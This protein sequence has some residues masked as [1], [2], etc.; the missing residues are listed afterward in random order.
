[1]KGLRILLV[2]ALFSIFL[3]SCNLNRYQGLIITVTEHGAVV[4]IET[5]YDEMPDSNYVKFLR[6]GYLSAVQEEEKVLGYRVEKEV[7]LIVGTKKVM[8]KAKENPCSAISYA[9]DHPDE[10]KFYKII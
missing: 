3:F 9:K 1:M 8:K 7:Y 4:P 5:E 10:I 6:M 2:T